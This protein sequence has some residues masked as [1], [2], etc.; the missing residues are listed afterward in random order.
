MKISYEEALIRMA[1][2]E[3]VHAERQGGSRWE[4]CI[5]GDNFCVRTAGSGLTFSRSCSSPE[6]RAQWAWFLPEKRWVHHGFVVGPGNLGFYE[7]WEPL[8]VGR[9]I[10]KKFNDMVEALGPG[11]SYKLTLEAA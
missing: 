2:G 3:I 5:I 7:D 8:I 4:V 11:A 9:D 10:A 1:K 6:S